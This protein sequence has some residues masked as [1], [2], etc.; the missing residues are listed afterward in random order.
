[1]E[2]VV[3][4]LTLAKMIKQFILLIILISFKVT[5]AQETFE[6]I[7]K[8]YLETIKTVQLY[9]AGDSRNQLRNPVIALQSNQQL[10]LEF[11]ELYEDAYDYQARIIHCNHDWQ[12]SGLSALQYL[13]DYNEF[14]LTEMEYSFGTITPY[15]HYKFRVP[16]TKISGNYLLVVFPRDYPDE[17]ILTRRFMVYE[18]WVSISSAA[19]IQNQS[20]QSI[21]R[22]NIQFSKLQ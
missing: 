20:V 2:S 21:D 3:N 12:P 9:P 7:D 4:L 13:D 22:Q 11:D 6:Y 10:I 8:A 16:K 1:M 18:K 19:E 15:V 17:V 14:N 5:I